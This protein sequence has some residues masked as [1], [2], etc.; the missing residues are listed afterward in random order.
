MNQI[1]TR[2]AETLPTEESPCINVTSNPWHACLMASGAKAVA[3][4]LVT[5][6]SDYTDRGLQAYRRD[7]TRALLA[8]SPS[9]I[10]TELARLQ[11]HYPDQGRPESLSDERWRDFVSDLSDLPPD[12]LAAACAG[13]RRSPARF[14]PTPGQLLESAGRIMA[15]RRAYLQRVDRVIAEL[16]AARAQAGKAPDA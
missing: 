4:K 16:A 15:Y 1:A 13:W 11:A 12:V 14:M 2:P 6:E 7:C 10:M 5:A 3:E 9:Q 8:A